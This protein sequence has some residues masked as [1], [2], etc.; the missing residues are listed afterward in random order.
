MV[1]DTDIRKMIVFPGTSALISSD[2]I[3]QHGND[4]DLQHNAIT[5]S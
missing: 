1:D 2:T 4:Y 3:G 5:A